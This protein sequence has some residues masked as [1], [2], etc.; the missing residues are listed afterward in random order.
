MNQKT[1]KVL[2]KISAIFRKSERGVKK[3]WNTLTP[4]QK[5]IT[6]RDF[7]EIIRK[8]NIEMRVLEAKRRQEAKEHIE[9]LESK[10]KK[11]K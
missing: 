4:E 3:M 11:E 9:K 8:N 1:A 2:K 6:R 5:E 7:E 10:I